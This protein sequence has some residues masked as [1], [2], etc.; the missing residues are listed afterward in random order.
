MKGF[1]DYNEG[2]AYVNQ[3][4]PFN[5]LLTCHVMSFGHPTTADPER[6]H[7]ITPYE[8]DRRLW[9]NREW[10]DQYTG[11]KFKISVTANHG[12]RKTARVKTY[13]DVLREYEFHPESKC[14]DGDGNP[15]NRETVGLLA[16]RHVR[17]RHI[18]PIGKESNG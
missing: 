4:K 1:E 18:T 9:L 7:L 12:T 3:I 16:R 6:F 5:F 11:N 17:I 14:A 8:R 15:C 13:G 2:K 10:T